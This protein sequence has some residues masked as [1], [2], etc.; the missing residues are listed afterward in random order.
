M[1]CDQP[2][3]FYATP[4]YLPN[5]SG[6]KQFEGNPKCHIP[7]VNF[8]LSPPSCSCDNCSRV[9]QFTLRLWL[10]HSCSYSWVLLNV[11]PLCPLETFSFYQSLCISE[12]HSRFTWLFALHR[13]RKLARLSES[14]LLGQTP[15]SVLSFGVMS[16]P[17]SQ[18]EVMTMAVT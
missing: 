3:F 6:R 15:L 14:P 18:R 1:S 11:C 12:I 17:V 7:C 4:H 2:H 10:A 5:R 9:L 16:R 8:Q 13:V